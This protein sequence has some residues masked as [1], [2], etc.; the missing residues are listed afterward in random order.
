MKIFK[1]RVTDA[2][3]SELTKD[4]FEKQTNLN[5]VTQSYFPCDT[6]VQD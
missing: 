2:G 5:A 3:Y 1:L 6:N 4:E